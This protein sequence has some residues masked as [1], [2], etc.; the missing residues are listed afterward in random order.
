MAT[1]TSVG[2]GLWSNATVWDTGVPV[3][4]DVVVIA[5]GHVVEFD[6]DQSG[7]ANGINGL[8][9]MGT[10]S[11]TR[12]T[13]TYYLKIK[14]AATINGAGTFDCGTSASPIPFASKHTITG[15]AGWY[16]NGAG[17]MTMTVYAAEPAN[18]FI[19]LSAIEAS[20]QTVLSVDTDVTGDIW[21]AGDTIRIDNTN[22]AVESEQRTIAV[23]GIAT[24]EITIT[25]GLTNAK[26]E[27]ALV[28]LITRN[29]KFAGVGSSGYVAQNFTSGKLN[30][31]GGQWTTANYRVFYSCADMTISGGTFSGNSYGVHN[32]VGA[33]ISGGTFSGNNT[34]VNSCVGAS[35]SGGT[36]SG[37]NHGVNSCSGA[38][39]SGGTFSG[40]DY[41]VSGC[42][43]TIKVAVFTSNNYDMYQSVFDGYGITLTAA[44][45]NGDYALLAKEIYSY[46][47]NYAGMG[48]Y[49][50]WTKGGVTE[51][52]AVT[53]PTGYTQAMQTVLE[54]A[55]VE[56]YWQKEIT[57]GAGASVNIE[58]NL[59]KDAAMTY[60]P[61]IVVFNKAST[62]PFAGGAGL[63]TFTMTNS[64]DTWED[65]LYTY[66]N[67]GTE[68]VT[69]IIRCQGMNATGNMYSALNIEQ[70][71]VDLTN[72]I[73]LVTAVK[74]KTDQLA[75]TVANQVD[76]N[77]LTG[78]ATAA[79][80]WG[81]STRTLTQSAASVIATVTGSDITC[82]RGDTLSASLTDVGALTGYSKVYFTVKRDYEDED[83]S[84]II[85]IEKT[86]GL[87]YILGVVATTAANGSITIDDEATGDIT[88]VLDEVETAK[89]SP[90]VYVYDVQ[91]FR[92]AGTVSTLTE[93]TFTV[94]A[95]VTR[96][97]A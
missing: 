6:V 7:F 79:E 3:D 66:T 36:F 49:K 23:G 76:A 94:S 61:R 84:A 32:C 33:S 28:L 80:V 55:S 13:G 34:G 63:H 88:I 12:T 43:A 22:K 19:K 65:D 40:N 45:P 89:L 86:A 70:I 83:T 78:G 93:G 29:V 8:T 56:G 46:I 2:S 24:G 14:A 64:I 20:G 69:L 42:A 31:G 51:T 16:I 72:T 54:N 30:V 15:G 62:D 41:G 17:G 9:I 25:A 50:A 5:T 21:Q 81:N 52:Q 95:D 37:N 38:S 68:D 74:A 27:G 4:D 71:N 82:Q 60:L 1:I 67:T 59:R 35:I 26:L 47:A 10:L 97:V 48:E 53:V 92:T 77:A 44:T 96:S 18:K 39:I 11:L 73:A 57:V 85:Q 58:M 91:I 90:G 87:K 75:F